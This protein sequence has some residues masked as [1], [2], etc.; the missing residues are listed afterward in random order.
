MRMMRIQGE[1]DRLLPT[2]RMTLE[3][4]LPVRSQEADEAWGVLPL[5]LELYQPGRTVRC[6]AQAIRVQTAPASA[7]HGGARTAVRETVRQ[8]G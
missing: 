7:A 4:R 6:T 3:T 1:Q 5:R 8:A 2:E